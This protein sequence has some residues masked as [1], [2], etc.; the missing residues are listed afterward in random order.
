MTA[1]EQAQIELPRPGPHG[2]GIGPLAAA[3]GVELTEILDLSATLNPLAPD[4]P[5]LVRTHAESI[6]RYPDS[7]HA[8]AALAEAIGVDRDRLLLTNGG[9]EA[10]A[11]VASELGTASITEPEFSLWR[12]HLRAVRAP[13]EGPQ[14]DQVRSNPNNPTGRLA[15]DDETAACWDEAFFPLVT[16]QWTRG[17]ADRGSIVVGSL[18][19][20]FACPG[21]RLGYVIGPDPEF[22]TRLGQRQPMWSVSTLATEVLPD[23]LGSADLRTWSAEL[24][25]LRNSLAELFGAAGFVADAADAPWILVHEVGWLRDALA[26]R[27]VLVR[28]CASFGLHETVR[29]AV[30]DAAGLER[31]ERTLDLVLA[32]RS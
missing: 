9:S 23:L 5:G 25:A 19:K 20:L 4:V 13:K 1:R 21:L 2:G 15:D 17:D 16:G 22:I 6:R 32:E 31:L 8:T 12:R 14:R 24:A 27:G 11:L 29:V 26:L 10:I 18:T 7:G 28:D 3:L 30:P